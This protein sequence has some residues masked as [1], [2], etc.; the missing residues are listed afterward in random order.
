MNDRGLSPEFSVP[1]CELC[2]AGFSA[3]QEVEVQRNC[4]GLILRREGCVEVSRSDLQK[5]GSDEST[6]WNF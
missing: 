1:D 4:V 3:L 5:D 6:M 2:G